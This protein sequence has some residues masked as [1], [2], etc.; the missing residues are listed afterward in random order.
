[1]G[2][3]FDV[4]MVEEIIYLLYFSCLFSHLMCSHT[5]IDSLNS[6]SI[7]R[8]VLIATVLYMPEGKISRQ[9]T[10]SSVT[11]IT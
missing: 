5:L 3:N 2:F 6:C 9:C 4:A 7:K 8:R 11:T 1:M 10:S